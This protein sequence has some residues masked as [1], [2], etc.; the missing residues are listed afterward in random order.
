[1]RFR[2]TEGILLACRCLLFSEV[3]EVGQEVMAAGSGNHL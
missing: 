2:P 1:M 3:K